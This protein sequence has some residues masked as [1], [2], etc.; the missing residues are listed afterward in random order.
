MV[1]MTAGGNEEGDGAQFTFEFYVQMRP[2]ESSLGIAYGL[3]LEIWMEWRGKAC[4]ETLLFEPTL[5]DRWN[6]ADATC[7]GGL[8]VQLK[9]ANIEPGLAYFMQGSRP[10]DA[11]PRP[12]LA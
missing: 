9:L 3:L 7:R 5:L 6:E 10:R 4:E 12:Q 1:G 2:G 8:P 11:A